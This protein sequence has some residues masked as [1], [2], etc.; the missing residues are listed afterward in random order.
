MVNHIGKSWIWR[1]KYY[2][3]VKMSSFII[4]YTLTSLWCTACVCCCAYVQSG[5]CRLSP[6]WDSAAHWA[7]VWCYVWAC[8]TTITAYLGDLGVRTAAVSGGGVHPSAL[9]RSTLLSEGAL[10]LLYAPAALKPGVCLQTHA[11]AVP[12]C[13]ALIQVGW[14][15]EEE[16]GDGEWTWRNCME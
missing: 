14:R 16:G 15:E 7:A 9:W 13:I 8:V 5:V 10:L 6:W 4:C 3:F 1:K 2:R 12:Q 11:T